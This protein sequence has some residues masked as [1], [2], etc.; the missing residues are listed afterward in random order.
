MI[1]Y[2]SKDSVQQEI[3]KNIQDSNRFPN[4]KWGSPLSAMST[5]IRALG[6]AIWMFIDQPMVSILKAIHPHTAEEA[7]LHEWLKRYG[8]N[9][10][11]ATPTRIYL[12]I[13]SSTKPLYT[14]EIPQ[15]V[16]VATGDEEIQF[17]TVSPVTLTDAVTEDAEGRYLVD[18]I[19]ECTELGTIGNVVP[20]SITEIMDF[21]D[22]VDVVY[23]PEEM[24]FNETLQKHEGTGESIFDSAGR[25]KETIDKVRERI[26]YKETGTEVVFTKDWYI[27]Q[28]LNN[29]NTVSK[30]IF[31]SSKELGRPGYVQLLVTGAPDQDGSPINVNTEEIETFFTS[32]ENQG[33]AQVEVKNTATVPIEVEYSINFAADSVPSQTALDGLV[34]SFFQ[35]LSD[36]ENFDP[37]KLQS[38]FLNIPGAGTCQ[39]TITSNPDVPTGSIAIPGPNFRVIGLAY[40]LTTV[41]VNLKY[42]VYFSTAE[43]K[44]P[45]EELESVVN[46]YFQTL[47]D[48]ENFVPGTLKA[49]FESLANV[50]SCEVLQV[51]GTAAP[52]EIITGN[53]SIAIKGSEFSVQ[54][55]VI[56]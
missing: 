13:G 5:F 7:E 48:G 51:D 30:V 39:V 6:N 36:G 15:G 4:H 8:M 11:Q 19:A 52:T 20:N 1:F 22:G 55:E 28:T 10:K 45:Q 29:F 43:N 40:A 26:Y 21:V 31:K 42:T 53:G 54:G 32:E 17:R 49:N 18:V 35:T 38:I 23:N 27:N 56:A 37:N 9:W 16:V 14:T 24:I 12:K 25:D 50:T 33:I 3:T 34:D 47:G 2:T 46:S 44:L 41:A